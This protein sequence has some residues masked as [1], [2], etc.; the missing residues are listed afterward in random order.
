MIDQVDTLQNL[1]NEREMN[2]DL[3][4]IKLSKLNSEK[5]MSSHYYNHMNL[6]NAMLWNIDYN[7]LKNNEFYNQ[8]KP[9]LQ[10]EVSDL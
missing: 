2:H 4:Q 5:M 9:R 3:W 10:I 8:L 7:T 1:Q 6:F